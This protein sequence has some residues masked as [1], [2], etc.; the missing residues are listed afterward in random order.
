MMGQ[1]TCYSVPSA[2][3][4]PNGGAHVTQDSLASQGVFNDP[5]IRR[6]GVFFWVLLFLLQ[7]PLYYGAGLNGWWDVL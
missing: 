4:N 6:K 3:S 1:K 7:V 2:H 5:P